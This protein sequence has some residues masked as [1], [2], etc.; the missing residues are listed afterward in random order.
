[1]EL[2]PR[3]ELNA[4]DATPDLG[5]GELCREPQART[6]EGLR[7][8][9]PLIWQVQV[10]VQGPGEGGQFRP[11]RQSLEKGHQAVGN[12]FPRDRPRG[13]FRE[14]IAGQGAG[15][16]V[17]RIRECCSGLVGRPEGNQMFSEGVCY[18]FVRW[19][20]LVRY[21]LQMGSD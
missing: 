16:P 17:S 20:R 6:E 11:D 8:K 18:L 10:W 5:T 9:C 19:A 15:L 1:M 13:C 3:R 14:M 12:V 2:G 21:D 7:V 4:G